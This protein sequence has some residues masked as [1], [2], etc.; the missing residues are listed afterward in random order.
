MQ[1][2]KEIPSV[3]LQS[4]LKRLQTNKIREHNE[5]N[6]LLN[7]V[8]FCSRYVHIISIKIWFHIICLTT[9]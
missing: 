9:E 6:L 3:A 2:E 4:I 8:S 7:S 5:N 1:D